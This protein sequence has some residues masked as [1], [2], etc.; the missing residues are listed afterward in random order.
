ME[1]ISKRVV[2]KQSGR[3]IGYLLDVAVDAELKKIGYYVVDEQTESEFF[4]SVFDLNT[5]GEV[6]FVES[7]MALQTFSGERERLVGKLVVDE[8]GVEYGSVKE[9]KFLDLKCQKLFTEKCEVLSKQVLRM[10]GDVIFLK[11]TKRKRRNKNLISRKVFYENRPE[12]S[13]VETPKRISLAAD[14]YIGKSVKSDVFGYNNERIVSRGEKITK[15]I[16]ENAKKHNKLNELF[17]VL[18]NRENI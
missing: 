14:Y 2:C 5:L 11:L 18:Q 4:V 13:F 10:C 15:N 3:V 9:L 12:D 16:F 7:E 6:A 17:F 8:N 1:N